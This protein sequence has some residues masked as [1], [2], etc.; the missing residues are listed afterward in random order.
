MTEARLTARAL[1]DAYWDYKIP[2]SPEAYAEQLGLTIVESGE[3]GIGASRLDVEQK[4]I[5]V[6]PHAGPE[7]RRFAFAQALGRYCLGFARSQA[8]LPGTDV[9][10]PVADEER[11]IDEFANC[12]LMPGIA[13]KAMVEVRKVRDPVTLRQAFGITSTVLYRRLKALGYFL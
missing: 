1:L 10:V 9:A 7:H 2:I 6:S 5:T 8:T 13:L 11:Q 12:L 4:R 3:V